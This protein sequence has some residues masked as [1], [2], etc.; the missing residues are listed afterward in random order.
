[1][2]RRSL[3]PY[4]YVVWR[5]EGRSRA[6]VDLVLLLADV[7]NTYRQPTAAARREA[8]VGHVGRRLDTGVD[9]LLVS[10]MWKLL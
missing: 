2:S 4:G 6:L 3:R 8:S 10:S 7:C 1:M 9:L 5:E